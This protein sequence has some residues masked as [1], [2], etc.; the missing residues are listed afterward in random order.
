MWKGSSGLLR[1]IPGGSSAG[2]W[3]GWK[4]ASMGP[5][6]QSPQAH[7]KGLGKV[8]LVPVP[9]GLGQLQGRA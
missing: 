7:L 6:V 5:R 9:R 8:L 1:G 4:L 3:L 2:V